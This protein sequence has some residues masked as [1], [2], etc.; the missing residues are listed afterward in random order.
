VCESATGTCQTSCVSQ[1]DCSGTN[2]CAPSG[3]CVPDEPSSSS[4][5]EGCSAAPGAFGAAHLRWAYALAT[6]CA[7]WARRRRRLALAA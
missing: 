1:R 2:L 7:L 5:R 3:K 6:V 4:S